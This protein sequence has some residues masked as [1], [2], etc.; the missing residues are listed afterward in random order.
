MNESAS[1][2][3]PVS[4]QPTISLAPAQNALC[5]L[6]ELARS[7]GRAAPSSGYL[8]HIARVLSR[9][10]LRLNAVLFGGLGSAL[11]PDREWSGFPEY[12]DALE[13]Q[14]PEDFRDTF[15]LRLAAAL[16]AGDMRGLLDDETAF[17]SHCTRDED[18]DATQE[19]LHELWTLLNDPVTFQR[20]L[21]SHLW[22]MWREFLEPD[23]QRAEPVLAAIARHY[24]KRLT[25]ASADVD[26]V[27]MVTGR[28]TASL[29]G[30]EREPNSVVLVPSAHLGKNPR[31]LHSETSAWVFFSIPE[32][33]ALYRRSPIGEAEL[34]V[35]LRALADETS[36]RILAILN[37]RCEAST[38]D[39]MRELELSQPNASRH[40]KQISS[41]G[42]VLQ[43]R[44]GGAAKAY[45][46]TPG[47]IELTFQA[48]ERYL[49]GD[50]PEL[51]V[52]SPS[53]NSELNRFLDD[54]GRLSAWP[55]KRHDQGLVLT[56][57]AGH[58]NPDREYSESDVNEILSRRHAWEDAATL[59]RALIDDRLMERSRD[60][61]RYWRADL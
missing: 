50:Q 40:L 36:W 33:P 18:G 5:T 42:F 60:G 2:N 1:A 28:D 19:N 3:Q 6:Q 20:V 30:S 34:L 54:E 16:Q 24:R 47:Q 59:R 41:A 56:Y 52:R 32:H 7:C 8:A 14:R 44:A 29:L 51:A 43:R 39:I 53:G 11:L 13:V 23:W 22:V 4:P 17:L 25:R 10:Q 27:R 15:L 48:V 45:S 57:L 31:V 49:S 46:F 38:Q 26:A 12:L 37:D 21:V 35:R 9:E 55:A 61:S 58:F